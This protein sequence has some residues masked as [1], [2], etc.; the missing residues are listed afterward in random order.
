MS[1]QSLIPVIPF[2][3]AIAKA[4]AVPKKKEHSRQNLYAEARKSMTTPKGDGTATTWHCSMTKPG[5]IELIGIVCVLNYSIK[6]I[7]T[8]TYSL[9]SYLS[10]S[11]S[12]ALSFN[13]PWA[14]DM[15]PILVPPDLSC[16]FLPS[17]L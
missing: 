3:V 12:L 8:L 11:L 9:S 7:K 15:H 16:F 17:C 2:G 6:T 13:F 14:H 1:K 10:I 5:G 4:R